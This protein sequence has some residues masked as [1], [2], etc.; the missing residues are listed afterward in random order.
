MRLA[1]AIFIAVTVVF[2]ITLA[3]IWT[4]VWGSPVRPILV[5]LAISLLVCAIGIPVGAAAFALLREFLG[6]GILARIVIGAVSGASACAMDAIL[7]LYALSKT[8]EAFYYVGL[9]GLAYTALAAGIMGAVFG[10][11][12]SQVE[13]DGGA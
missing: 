6:Q 12:A 10:S 9:I 2:V 3:L 8:G 13:H 11:G 7:V 1:R 4:A 5:S